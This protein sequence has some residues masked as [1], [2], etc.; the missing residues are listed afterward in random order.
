MRHEFLR[1]EAETGAR[2]ALVT[3]SPS[4]CPSADRALVADIEVLVVA[5]RPI[6]AQLLGLVNN[7]SVGPAMS[8]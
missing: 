5:R 1:T 3:D 4:T 2:A 6:G 7:A 8:P